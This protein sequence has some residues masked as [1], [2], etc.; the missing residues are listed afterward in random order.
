MNEQ[1]TGDVVG[2]MH[3]HKITG[4]QLAAEIGWNEKYLSQILNGLATSKCAEEKVCSALERL[5]CSAKV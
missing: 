1:W 4:K 5:I 2:K 3:V